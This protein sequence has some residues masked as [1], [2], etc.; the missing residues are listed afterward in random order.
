MKPNE[1]FV[2]VILTI[3][4]M[5]GVL[6]VSS[7]AQTTTYRVTVNTTGNG[8]VSCGVMDPLGNILDPYYLWQSNCNA[9]PPY[10]A[11]RIVVFAA[12]SPLGTILSSWG[13]A[14]AGADIN[15]VS[16]DNFHNGYLCRVTLNSDTTVTANFT[17][18]P[19]S[20]YLVNTLTGGTG[21]GYVACGIGGSSN[22]PS[23]PVAAGTPELFTAVP[24]FGSTFASWGDDCAG[25]GTINP[26]RC[27]A[28]INSNFTAL[29]NFLPGT[30]TLSMTTGGTGTGTI[31]CAGGPCP[32]SI[33]AGSLIG[34][35]GTPDNGSVFSSWGGV[36]AGQPV[37]SPCY[38]KAYSTNGIVS[39]SAIFN[40][41]SRLTLNITGNGTGIFTSSPPGISCATGSNRGCSA[42]FLP[43]QPVLLTFTSRN[44]S[45]V[46]NWGGCLPTSATT[47][48]VTL[49]KNI[50]LNI[51]VNAPKPTPTSV[52]STS[53]T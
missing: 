33:V 35:I 50:F 3:A 38:Y 32:S 46:A 51:T 48:T 23:T 5:L 43:N 27:F 20:T 21:T 8:Y 28:T 25:I 9:S 10:P 7:Q 19:A 24:T 13:G 29:A 6:P 31:T 44:N 26:P 45:S 18:P 16:S 15:P 39:V 36:C 53:A 30:Y 37:A 1:K 17:T 41:E 2:A 14:C 42:T 34:F 11:G 40:S 12:S 4:A 22:C 52:Q 47:C 49:D